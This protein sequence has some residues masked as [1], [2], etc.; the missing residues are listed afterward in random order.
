MVNQQFQFA[1]HILLLLA[2]SDGLL[3]S[4]AIA[5]SANTNPVVVRRLLLALRRAGLVVTISGCHGGAM[6]ARPPHRISLLDVYDAIQLRPAICVQKRRVCSH[7]QVSR[8]IK[9]VLAAVSSQA[10]RALRRE[11]RR[12]S[13]A[14]MAR[15]IRLLAS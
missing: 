8:N 15:R 6:L 7:C 2:H 12:I 14:T 13:I 1:I 4:S 10:E 3:D 11:L 5:L 9:P